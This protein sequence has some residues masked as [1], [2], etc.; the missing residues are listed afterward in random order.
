MAEIVPHLLCKHTT[1]TPERLQNH[2]NK[3]LVSSLNHL[4]D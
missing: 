3:L 2:I 1:I 4:V